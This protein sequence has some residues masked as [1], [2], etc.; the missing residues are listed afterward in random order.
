MLHC[1][2]R[3][4]LR[5]QTHLCQKQRPLLLPKRSSRRTMQ[6]PQQPILRFPRP[7]QMRRPRLPP[8]RYCWR[9]PQLPPRNFQKRQRP[10]PRR[11]LRPLPR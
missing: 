2:K 5:Q 7:R 1:P 3:R 8:L 6:P 4:L 10:L 9:M 11:C